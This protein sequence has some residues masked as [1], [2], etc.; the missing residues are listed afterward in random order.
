VIPAAVLVAEAAAPAVVQAAAAAIQ[1]VVRAA[2]AVIPEATAI[3]T[4][5]QAQNE[6]GRAEQLT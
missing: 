1:A 5:R 2:A 3:R 4:I 6:A